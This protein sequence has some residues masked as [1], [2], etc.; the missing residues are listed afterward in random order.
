MMTGSSGNAFGGPWAQLAAQRSSAATT[1]IESVSEQP[2]EDVTRE[3]QNKNLFSVVAKDDKIRFN[4][5]TS[6]KT[7][8]GNSGH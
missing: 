1:M 2:L 4:V 3:I 6:R 7:E 5:A 8:R